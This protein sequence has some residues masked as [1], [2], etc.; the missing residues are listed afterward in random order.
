VRSGV[1]SEVTSRKLLVIVVSGMCEEQSDE[2]KV[3]LFYTPVASLKPMLLIG[4]MLS[5]RSSP[6]LQSSSPYANSPN[7]LPCLP[8]PRVAPLGTGNVGNSPDP[9]PL[10][11]VHRNLGYRAC[12]PH[13]LGVE[14]VEGA[15]QASVVG[16]NK[17]R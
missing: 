1:R 7:L 2:Q 15:V 17:L 10:F 12:R 14:L 5:L 4:D 8:L 11:H 6:P 13:E 16:D 3:P 9:N